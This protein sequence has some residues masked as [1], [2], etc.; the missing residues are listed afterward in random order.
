[1]ATRA[2]R[3]K[4]R[5]RRVSIEKS[6]VLGEL[7]TKHGFKI[8]DFTDPKAMVPIY[9]AA[10]QGKNLMLLPSTR[11]KLREFFAG[12]TRKQIDALAT[13]HDLP[14]LTMA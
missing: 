13:A 8:I 11:V 12:L 7:L 5:Q 4:S 2:A 1:M 10:K 14:L 3:A 9:E 6:E